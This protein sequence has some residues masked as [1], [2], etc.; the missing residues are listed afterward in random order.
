MD[1]ANKVSAELM[2]VCESRPSTIFVPVSMSGD[3]IKAACKVFA[4][5]ELGQGSER[6]AAVFALVLIKDSCL[7]CQSDPSYGF[8]TCRSLVQDFLFQHF[9]ALCHLFDLNPDKP[10]YDRLNAYL[11]R[12]TIPPAFTDLI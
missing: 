12:E 9:Q 11:I 7:G 3:F 4:S 6:A 1:N 5:R 10:H 8:H 2:Q